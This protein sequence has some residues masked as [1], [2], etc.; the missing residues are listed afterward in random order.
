MK[1]AGIIECLSNKDTVD[2]VVEIEIEIDRKWNR[3]RELW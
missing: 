2:I 1:S 3:E